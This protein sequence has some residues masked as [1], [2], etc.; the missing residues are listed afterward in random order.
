[1]DQCGQ[2]AGIEPLPCRFER[3]HFI[4]H[5]IAVKGSVLAALLQQLVLEVV[6]VNRQPLFAL[7]L[8]RLDERGLAVDLPAP[9]GPARTGAFRSG[10]TSEPDSMKWARISLCSRLRS[11]RGSPRGR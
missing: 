5:Q 3:A 4:R 7:R 11:C 10:R 9:G 6:G 1:M 2:L 8:G